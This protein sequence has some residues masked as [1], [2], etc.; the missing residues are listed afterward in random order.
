MP[1]VFT[2]S[3]LMSPNTG[4]LL[5]PLLSPVTAVLC[6]VL[7]FCAFAAGL[8]SRTQGGT[9]CRFPDPFLLCM[10]LQSPPHLQF[11]SLRPC[12]KHKAY[13]PDGG[14]LLGSMIRY[15]VCPP[16]RHVPSIPGAPGMCWSLFFVCLSVES[17][18]SLCTIWALETHCKRDGQG[19]HHCGA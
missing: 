5:K 6:Q 13:P 8:Q 10:T 7:A 15:P 1:Q 18:C 3:E 9:L 12:Q 17:S 19:S 16:H 14:R 11:R 4:W 2:G